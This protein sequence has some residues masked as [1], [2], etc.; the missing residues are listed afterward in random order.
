MAVINALKET[1]KTAVELAFE[2]YA[3]LQ[4]EVKVYEAKIKEIKARKE[5]VDAKAEIVACCKCSKGKL[6]HMGLTATWVH[7]DEFVTRAQE[8]VTITGM[9]H[10]EL[11]EVDDKVKDA[12]ELLIAIFANAE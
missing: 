6:S 5:Y 12:I 3:K 8:Y 11:P 7:K 1:P 10:V 2:K 4:A 9:P